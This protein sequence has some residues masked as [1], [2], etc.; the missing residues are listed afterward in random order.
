MADVPEL[1]GGRYEVGELLG[2]G[3]M[4]EVHQGFD[5]RLGRPVAIK[6][7][8]HDLARDATFLT[9][10][11]REA[12]SAAALNHA[13]IVAVY[14]HG[15]DHVVTESGGATFNV[16]YIVMEYVDGRTLRE[17]LSEQGQ[18][19]PTYAIRVT[20]GVLDALGYSHRQGI[21]HRD[22]KPANVM[23][24]ADGAVKVMDFGIARAMAD[25]NATVTA[26]QAVIG[27]AQ[28]L[29][30]EQAQ[31]HPVDARSDL[32]SAGCMLFELLTGRPPFLGDSPVSIAYQHVGETPVPPSRFVDEGLPEDLDAVVLHALE[33]PREDRY[34]DAAAFRQDL[35]A[36]RLG[37]PVSAAAR[38][39]AAAL[40]AAAAGLSG[41]TAAG[42]TA[43]LPRTS[44]L[45]EQTAA[46]QV[47]AAA[48]VPSPPVT[49][50][51]PYDD[52]DDRRRRGPGAYIA[53]AI[54]VLAALALLGYGLFNY[55][56]APDGPPQVT[57]PS[58]VGAPQQTAEA[59]LAQAGFKV[60]SVVAADD[61]VPEGE[62]I[63]QTPNGNT[64]ADQGSTVRITVS[65]G[66]DAVQVPDLRGKSLS[67]ATQVLSDIGLTVGTVTKTD[68]PNAAAN[69][70]IS[71]DPAAG[72]DAKPGTRVNLEV[73]TG[74]VAV[75]NVEGLTQNEAQRQL[76]DA[77]LQV[78]TE[79]KQTNDVAEGNV[80]SQSPKAASKVDTG[81]TVKIVVAQKAAPTVTPTT[82]A[83]TPTPTPSATPSPSES[84]TP[85]TPPTK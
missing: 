10:F 58:V 85:T 77:N 78:E 57:V 28:Y 70:V 64:Q 55:L 7:L 32:Y 9:R 12:Q 62:V 39:S 72:N 5:T 80:I 2:R 21:V 22:I 24:G 44:P 26:T 33:K 76:A 36:V 40:A 51:R 35:Q 50:E 11:R 63:S 29:S 30:P 54:A 18:L 46:Y 43:A 25:A 60:E 38:A 81:S 16:P 79:Y 75:P 42:A 49:D 20:E 84:P 1:L 34:Q 4:A 69:E 31:G 19:D 17:V 8:R 83:P 65:G 13:S 53:L 3:G 45:S 67:E 68:D 71:S 6:L 15:E 73:G 74:K 52:D 66:P 14:D 48:P 47:P 27:T 59:K 82:V 56:G 41:A 23:I 37:R 61:T